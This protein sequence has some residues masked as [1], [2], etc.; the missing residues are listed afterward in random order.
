M[1]IVTS[2]Q[3]LFNRPTFTNLDMTRIKDKSHT[4]VSYS[5]HQ[6]I[7]IINIIAISSLTVENQLQPLEISMLIGRFVTRD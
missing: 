1:D 7:I 2:R 3:S 6:D 4:G 5:G